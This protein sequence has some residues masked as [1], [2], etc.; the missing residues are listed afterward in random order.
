MAKG[1]ERE[2]GPV[3]MEVLPGDFLRVS[4]AGGVWGGIWDP[5]DIGQPLVNSGGPLAC[6]GP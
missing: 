4:D 5:L 6:D 1:L 2:C 3:G